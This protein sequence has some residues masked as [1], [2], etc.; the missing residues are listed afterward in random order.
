MVFLKWRTFELVVPVSFTAKLTS[1]HP[2][3][4]DIS[5]RYIEQPI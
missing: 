5:L 4:M 1:G 3:Q 2:S